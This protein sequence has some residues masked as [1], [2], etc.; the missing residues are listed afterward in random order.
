MLKLERL[1]HNRV[2]NISLRDKE[3]VISRTFL[4]A[5]AVAI[6]FHF[7]GFVLFHVQPFKADRTESLF[8]PVEVNTSVGEEGTHA[9]VGEGKQLRRYHLEPELSKPTFPL[10]PQAPLKREIHSVNHPGVNVHPFQE[11]EEVSLFPVLFD[12]PEI[13]HPPL[14]VIVSGPLAEKKLE[15]VPELKHVP[16][17]M[18]AHY[19]VQ[20]DDQTGR[21]FW[22]EILEDTKSSDITESILEKLRFEQ[23]PKGFVTDGFVDIVLTP[24]GRSD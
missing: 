15:E 14:S 17:A 19:H 8:P 7:I 13:R 11:L 23:D 5:L 24:G 20:I 18:L 21:I 2:I 12:L 3:K 9:E 10:F 16:E 6:G 4:Q 1:S 22:Y